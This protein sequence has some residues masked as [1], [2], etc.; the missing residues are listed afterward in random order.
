MI[1]QDQASAFAP[2]K[3]Q[4]QRTS[5]EVYTE[6]PQAVWSTCGG[7]GFLARREGQ[8]IGDFQNSGGVNEKVLGLDVAMGDVVSVAEVEVGDD[9][10]EVAAGGG[11]LWQ[12]CLYP[13]DDPKDMVEPVVNETKN[14]IIAAAEAKVRCVVFTSSIGAVTMDPK[15]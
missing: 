9:L 11:R 3:P 2:S 1:P 12:S 4:Q 8:K 5:G 6:V 10:L 7:A 13:I 15:Q 14:V